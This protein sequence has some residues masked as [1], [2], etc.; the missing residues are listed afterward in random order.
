M[1][2]APAA[3]AGMELDSGMSS[4]AKRRRTTNSDLYDLFTTEEGVPGA[5]KTTQGANSK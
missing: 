1:D 3:A 4:D 5:P 2:A